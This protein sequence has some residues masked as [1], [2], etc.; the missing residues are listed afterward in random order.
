M[1][2]LIVSGQNALA[3]LRR[4]NRRAYTFAYA[5]TCLAIAIWAIGL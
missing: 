3:R 4:R 2:T 5:M 1:T